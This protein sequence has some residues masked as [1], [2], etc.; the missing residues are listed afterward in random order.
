[1]SAEIREVRGDRR[2]FLPLL[3]LADE[4]EDM[5]GRYLDRGTLFALYDGG[6]A[7]AVCLVTEEGEGVYEVKNLAVAPE[8]Q[9]RGY[10]RALL[11]FVC[12]RCRGGH[13]LLVGTG[14]SPRT[15]PFY[16][17]CGFTYSHR[18]KDFF[19]AHYDHPIVEDGMLLRDMV[20]FRRSL[21]GGAAKE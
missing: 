6:E 9:R 7:R 16:E 15:V 18:I 4:Q 2:A 14:E 1:M 12:R 20:Y 11:A 21:K 10:G 19:T 17:R 8:Y 5:I 13:T 3:L